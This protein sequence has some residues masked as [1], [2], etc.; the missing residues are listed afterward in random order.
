MTNIPNPSPSPRVLHNYAAHLTRGSGG[1]LARCRLEMFPLSSE[2]LYQCLSNTAS[3]KSSAETIT[4]L[5]ENKVLQY[6]SPAMK[7]VPPHASGEGIC[8]TSVQAEG[9]ASTYLGVGLNGRNNME[10]V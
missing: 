6:S 4:W 10:Q 3:E 9:S 7:M 1:K 5:I 2:F 8:P